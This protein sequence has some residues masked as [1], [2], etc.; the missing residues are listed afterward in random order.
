VKKSK[1]M[2]S[3]RAKAMKFV[4]AQQQK[5][6]AITVVATADSTALVKLIAP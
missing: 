6:S 3:L 2:I 4:I 5:G 1:L